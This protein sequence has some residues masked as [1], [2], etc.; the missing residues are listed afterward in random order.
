M[1]LR[2]DVQFRFYFS[3]LAGSQPVKL[4][5]VMESDKQIRAGG[6]KKAQHLSAT[7]L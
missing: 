2:N 6:N 4:T 7:A 3:D 1:I 5:K